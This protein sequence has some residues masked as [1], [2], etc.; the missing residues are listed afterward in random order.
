MKDLIS[1]HFLELRLTLDKSK[2]TCIVEHSGGFEE[3]W[4][5]G[6]ECTGARGEEEV[7][8]CS[9]ELC[10]VSQTMNEFIRGLSVDDIK[11][12]SL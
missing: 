7:N 3:V 10:W 5:N 2:N 1:G 6:D 12:S 4:R 8:R 11:K 9:L